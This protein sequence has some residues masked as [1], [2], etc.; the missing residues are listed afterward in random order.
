M[1]K[2]P[3]SPVWWGFQRPHCHPRWLTWVSLNARL[4]GIDGRENNM[5]R[6]SG[7]VG[8]FFLGGMIAAACNSTGTATGSAYTDGY[9]YGNS[10]WPRPRTTG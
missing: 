1:P 6:K 2:C 8:L 5:A 10:Y 3:T 7:V 9:N 4:T